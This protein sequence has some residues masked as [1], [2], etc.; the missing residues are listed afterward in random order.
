MS[1]PNFY[2]YYVVALARAKSAAARA[3]VRGR[4]PLEAQATFIEA[5]LTTF[6]RS[7]DQIAEGLG[8]PESDVWNV[9]ARL[10][11]YRRAA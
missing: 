9:R 4:D 3:R 2:S 5:A 8:I 7:T 11:R 6:R 10:D 1:E